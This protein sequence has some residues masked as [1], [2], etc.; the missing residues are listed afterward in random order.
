MD[1]REFV[2]TCDDDLFANRFDSTDLHDV[3]ALSNPS[4]SD[5]VDAELLGVPSDVQVLGSNASPQPLL[6]VSFLQLVDN[7]PTIC[8]SCSITP[9]TMFFQ[10]PSTAT[11]RGNSTIDIVSTFPLKKRYPRA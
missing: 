4:F 7:I 2:T 3:E 9:E 8:D 6:S 1:L 11:A 5:P 10:F